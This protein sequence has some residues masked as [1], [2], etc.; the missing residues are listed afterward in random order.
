MDAPKAAPNHVAGWGPSLYSHRTPELCLGKST[1]AFSFVCPSFLRLGRSWFAGRFALV[2]RAS[3]LAFLGLLGAVARQVQLHDHAVVD[4]PVD[5]RRRRHR[6]LEDRLPARERQ[7]A[8]RWA[9]CRAGDTSVPTWRPCRRGEQLPLWQSLPV[10]LAQ[11]PYLLVGD[12][13][14]P[15]WKRAL[16]DVDLLANR[17][18]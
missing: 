12:H 15:P 4:Q 18:F 10:E 17:E 11:L 13:R 5:R 2:G 8:R 9:A 14:E 16:D 7:V 3:L 6:V 1:P